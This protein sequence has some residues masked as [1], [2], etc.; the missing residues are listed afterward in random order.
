MLV[1]S[2]N[3]QQKSHTPNQKLSIFQQQLQQQQQKICNE[4][5]DEQWTHWHQFKIE[6]HTEKKDTTK[7]TTELVLQH[8]KW[9]Q[10]EYVCHVKYINFIKSA[11][12]LQAIR[13]NQL[14]Y[15]QYTLISCMNSLFGWK[16]IIEKKTEK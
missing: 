2:T 3:L 13:N 6:M 12:H 14:L 16:K 7:R 11:S 9:M 4:S 15:R 5:R 1:I 8:L 10:P